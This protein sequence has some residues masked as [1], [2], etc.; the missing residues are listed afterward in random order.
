[1]KPKKS[2]FGYFVNILFLLGILYALVCGVGSLGAGREYPYLMRGAFFLLLLA[3]WCLLNGGL[4]LAARLE[5]EDAAEK[6]RRALNIAEAVF[7]LAA[8][9]AA[10]W[11]RLKAIAAFPMQPE[12]DFK[13]YYEI[14]DLLNKGTIQKNGAGYCAYLALFP[15]AYGYSQ[16]LASLFRRFGTQVSVGQYGNLALS[17]ATV[18]FVYRTGRLIGGRLAGLTALLLSAFWPSQVLYC[19]Q[20]ASEFLAAFLL[21]L[22]VYL[23]VLSLKVCTA[24]MKHPGIGV[25]LYI[26]IGVTLGFCGTVSN[27]TVLVIAAIFLC[28]FPRKLFL[29]ARQSQNPSI[30]MAILSRG[31]MRCLLVLLCYVLIVAGNNITVKQVI[32][33]KPASDGA[34]FGYQL[35]VGLNAGSEGGWNAEDSAYLY[36]TYDALGDANQAHLVCRDLAVNRLK[37]NPK[38]AANLMLKKLDRIWGND[39]YGV[40][41]N[42]DLL[43]QSGNLTQERNSALLRLSDMGNLFYLLTIAFAGIA[44]IFLWRKG[45]GLEYVPVLITVGFMGANVLMESQNRHHYHAL[46]M[47]ALLA[48]CAVHEIY[49]M[50][51]AKVLKLRVEQEEKRAS[52]Q[53]RQEQVNKMRRDEAELTHL[54]EEA[55]QSKFDMKDALE[56]NLIRVSV[57]EAY[58]QEDKRDET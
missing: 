48:G 2:V 13:T 22:G 56:R 14:A 50:N 9:G 26:A 45:S 6:H 15:H 55:M 37:S 42:V 25:L 17:V 39:G 51:R 1:M 28:I 16:F 49:Q 32:G 41:W 44:G 53:E 31:W 3:A 54:R 27:M 40:A 34:S 43:Q 19:N 47:L 18:F 23:F 5:W 46:F 7:V 33:R 35:L 38:A 4:A 20:L 21:T 24:K 29:D 58:H 10:V 30:S 36:D 11:V 52:L 8:L 12:S 57:T